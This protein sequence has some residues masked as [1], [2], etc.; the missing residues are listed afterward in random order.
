MSLYTQGHFT[1]I[2]AKV[3]ELLYEIPFI[4]N[5]KGGGQCCYKSATNSGYNLQLLNFTMFT[6]HGTETP[7]GLD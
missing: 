1:H 6:K 4:H 2:T 7:D 5:C 3:G